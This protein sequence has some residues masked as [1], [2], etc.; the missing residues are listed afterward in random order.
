M[1]DKPDLEA[2]IAQRVSLFLADISK[3]HPDYSKYQLVCTQ[4]LEVCKGNKQGSAGKGKKDS[5]SDASNGDD[6]N[7]AEGNKKK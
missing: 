7:N 3:D 4:V 2:Q 1:G 5:G 6:G